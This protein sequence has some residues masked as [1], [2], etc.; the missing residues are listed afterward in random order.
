MSLKKR[1]II[2]PLLNE[3]KIAEHQIIEHRI[4]VNMSSLGKEL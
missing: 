2:K 4:R 1:F 3:K